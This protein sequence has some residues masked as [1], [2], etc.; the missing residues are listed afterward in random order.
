VIF[1][2]G[3]A[4]DDVLLTEL[5]H[6]DTEEE[7]MEAPIP[8]RDLASPA[9]LAAFDDVLARLRMLERFG[10]YRGT[11]DAGVGLGVVLYLST[12]ITLSVLTV[13]QPGLAT[14]LC[15]L[16]RRFLPDNFVFTSIQLTKNLRSPLHVDRCV[17]GSIFS[18]VL[19]SCRKKIILQ[20]FFFAVVSF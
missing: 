17:V 10:K 18:F 1:D 12:G 20:L 14:S 9:R 15:D 13:E 16:A 8:A 6:V 3:D 19:L 7:E 5:K 4:A 11:S 2:D